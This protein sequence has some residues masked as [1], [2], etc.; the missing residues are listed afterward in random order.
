M[1]QEPEYRL[2]TAFRL[3]MSDR[4]FMS[5]VTPNFFT[6]FTVP[7]LKS[8]QKPAMYPDTG[9]WRGP[10]TA[11]KNLEVW[12]KAIWKPELLTTRTK[13]PTA[14]S[15]PNVT[16]TVVPKYMYSLLEV[17]LKLQAHSLLEDYNAGG[18]TKDER[19]RLNDPET[20]DVLRLIAEEDPDK[21]EG[22][23]MDDPKWLEEYALSRYGGRSVLSRN[24]YRP[25]DVAIL[26]PNTEWIVG[27]DQTIRF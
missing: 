27:F 12:S 18:L 5:N 3:T 21:W 4:R 26:M 11:T 16:Y 6:R 17:A 19:V 8:G 2:F 14:R 24:P 20:R 9:N 22:V 23:Y 1:R 7:L 13:G 15:D 25:A 10:V